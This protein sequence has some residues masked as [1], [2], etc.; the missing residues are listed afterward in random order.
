MAKVQ[1]GGHTFNAEP[2]EDLGNGKWSMRALQSGPRTA[3][4]TII[5]VAQNEIVEMASAETPP[6]YDLELAMA[7]ERETLPTFAE[8]HARNQ[9]GKQP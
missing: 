6:P 9:K 7:K 4:G 8:I 1:W 2:I 3:K 5:T